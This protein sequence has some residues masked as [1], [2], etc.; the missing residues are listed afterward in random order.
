MCGNVSG[1]NETGY[2]FRE[3]AILTATANTGYRF[4]GWFKVVGINDYG[5][6]TQPTITLPMSESITIYARF[7][8]ESKCAV[9]FV[10]N[11]G[12]I[13][14][15][16]Y[17]S[18]G[19]KIGI[20]PT[21]GGALGNLFKGW[22]DSKKGGTS[23]SKD[24]VVSQ[25][26]TVYARYER[27]PGSLYRVQVVDGFINQNITITDGTFA[28]L[29]KITVTPIDVSG[30][31]FQYWM[32]NS[33]IVSYDRNYSFEVKAAVNLKAVFGDLPAE[34]KSVAGIALGEKDATAGKIYFVV[35]RN[36][37][38]SCT[39]VEA[40]V[41]L[42]KNPNSVLTMLSD[43]TV[44]PGVIKSPSIYTFKEGTVVQ[45]VKVPSSTAMISICS[46]VVYRTADGKTYVSYSRTLTVSLESV[47]LEPPAGV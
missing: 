37:A 18:T 6:G 27:N 13:C 30:K 9:S 38:E 15:V 43:Y 17:V 40:G 11:S 23:I 32:K 35:E 26:M 41:L 12:T 20:L 45:G 24:T 3:E 46:Y 34:V 47:D 42:S 4:V 25:D 36:V 33:E 19:S 44:Q 2:R 14:Q 7:V 21:V 29:T 22:F 5:I 31:Q 39:L 28:Y 1:K 8:E 10:D 16:A